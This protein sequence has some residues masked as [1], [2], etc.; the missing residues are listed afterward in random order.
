MLILKTES[1]IMKSFKQF[2]LESEQYNDLKQN[3]KKMNLSDF[4]TRYSVEKDNIRNQ[5]HLPPHHYFNIS[6][7]DPSEHDSWDKPDL[8]SSMEK[9]VEQNRNNI[10]QG[11]TSPS[12]L[13]KGRPDDSKWNPQVIDGHQRVIAA[14]REGIKKV[15]GWFDDTT[16]KEIHKY[17]NTKT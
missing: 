6:N 15:P 13:I 3:A 8:S 1:Q 11:K 4:L 16:L 10:K 2:L 5:D 17:A 14:Y 7:I 12:I 9:Q